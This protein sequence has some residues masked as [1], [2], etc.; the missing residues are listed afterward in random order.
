MANLRKTRNIELSLFVFHKSRHIYVGQNHDI[1]VNQKIMASLYPADHGPRT[2]T[3][4]PFWALETK[5]V[6]TFCA[7]PGP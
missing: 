6:G 5:R 3:Y 7:K 1:Q 2:S 4:L